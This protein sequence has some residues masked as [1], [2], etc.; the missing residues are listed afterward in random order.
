MISVSEKWAQSIFDF[1]IH[2]KLEKNLAD[3]TI[4]SYVRDV[5][6]LSS[7]CIEQGQIPPN[8]VKESE[9][10][11]CIENLLRSNYSNKSQARLLS[12]F[13][14]FFKF[15]LLENNLDYDPTALIDGPKVSKSLPDVLEISE[16][17]EMLNCIDL[18]LPQGHRNRA[19]LETLYASGLRVS[20]LINLKLT[21][22]YLDL[23]VLKVIGKGDK[24]RWVPIGPDALAQIN[25]YVQHERS[26]LKIAKGHEDF[27][28]LNRRG[29]KL[30]REMIFLII[31]DTAAKANIQKDISPHTFR[32]SFATHLVEGGADL[33][34]VQEMLGHESIT[35][36]EIYT[37]L[38]T[39]FLRATVLQYHPINKISK[40]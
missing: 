12:G 25:N 28:F 37:H 1:K 10:T 40:T 16:I 27:V 17:M 26:S 29:K 13:K 2:L 31:K 8:Q 24:E 36:T 18:S 23:G 35:T 4:E 19:I 39:A 32:H 22:L 6:K 21:N 38:D 34:A 9:I 14:S 33:R 15:L 30:T 20:E 5:E 11:A 7:F 3:N